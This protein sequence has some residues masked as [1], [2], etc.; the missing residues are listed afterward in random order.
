MENDNDS[1]SAYDPMLIEQDFARSAWF[2]ARFAAWFGPMARRDVLF[3]GAR[4]EEFF[5]PF[6]NVCPQHGPRHRPDSPRHRR[7][8]AGDLM[9]LRRNVTDQTCVGPSNSDIKHRSAW[10]HHLSGH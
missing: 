2:D 8:E 5:G 6:N 7:N 4:G 3:Y 10:F 9:H 1:V